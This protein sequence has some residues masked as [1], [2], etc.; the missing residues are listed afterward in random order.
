M[1][2]VLVDT[3]ILIDVARNI[4]TAVDYLDEQ[5][6]RS[7]LAVSTITVMELLVGCRNKTEQRKVERF[8]QRFVLLKLDEQISDK[9]VDLLRQYRLSHGLLMPDALI[10]A[11]AL[12]ND[13][14]LVTKNQRDY[15]FIADL[16]LSPFP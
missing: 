11:T 5:A 15:R 9:A 7:T 2:N 4:Q 1:S 3:D 10:A 13:T 14:G 8:L 16:Q 12:V 6:R